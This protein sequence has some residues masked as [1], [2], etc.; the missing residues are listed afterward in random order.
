LGSIKD[1]DTS[2]PQ[3]LAHQA[4]NGDFVFVSGTDVRGV[5]LSESV[6]SGDARVRVLRP[7]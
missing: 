2:E 3:Q 7:L 1:T 5:F 6:H 4:L